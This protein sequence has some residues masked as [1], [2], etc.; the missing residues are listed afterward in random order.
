[1]INR[2]QPIQNILVGIIIFS[3]LLR[4][5]VALWLGD[6]AEPISGAYDQVSYDTLAQSVLAGKGFSFPTNWYPFTLA[7]EPTAHW[8]YLYSIYLAG[9]YAVVGHYPLAAR[10][11]QVLLSGLNIWLVYR[12]GRRLFGE[13]VG[14]VAAALTSVYAYFVFFN[15]ALMTQTFYIIAVLAVVELALALIEHPTRRSWILLGIAMGIGAL[16]RQTLL[17]FA[18]VA[19]ASIILARRWQVQWR[20]VLVSVGVIGIL[21]LPWTVYNYVTFHDFMLLNSNGGYWF[22]SSN[23][24]AQG[25]NFNQNF[26]APLP[27]ELRGMSEPVID[28]ALFREG[29]GFIAADPVRFLLLSLNRVKDYFWFSP[30]EQSTLVSNLARIL[31]FALYLPFMIYGLWLSR[32]RW[33]V[34]VPL[35]LYVAFDTTLCLASWAAPRYRLPSDAILMV[36][37]GLAVVSLATRLKLISPSGASQ[38]F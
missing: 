34:C 32:G 26:A 7:N 21:I 18:P 13:W 5:I 12:I 24:P 37:A 30:S 2:K 15:A 3:I 29:L 17:I 33:R 6:R 20:D 9:V 27:A 38:Q 16:F 35:Y 25:T 36:F 11:V 31:S 19:F 1:M 8:S 28:R 22:Y 4:V 10:L 14:L 23:H